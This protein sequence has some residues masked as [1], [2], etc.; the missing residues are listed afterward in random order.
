MVNINGIIQ[1]FIDNSNKTIRTCNKS[2]TLKNNR[3][4][5]FNNL[6]ALKQDNNIIILDKTKKGNCFISIRTSAHIT[7]I[8]NYMM[9]HNIDINMINKNRFHEIDE[10]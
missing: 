6:I 3:L 7:M 8:I 9:L 5:S 4:Y 2:F 10:L 1:K